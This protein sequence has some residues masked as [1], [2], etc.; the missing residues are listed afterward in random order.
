MPASHLH[1]EA[2]LIRLRRVFG[3]PHLL[4]KNLRRSDFGTSH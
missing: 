1:A 2:G 4:R 3:K